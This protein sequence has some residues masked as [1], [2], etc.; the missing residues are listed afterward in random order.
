MRAAAN[1]TNGRPSRVVGVG[2]RRRR[3][4]PACMRARLAGVRAMSPASVRG[5]HL[6]RPRTPAAAM[7]AA[8]ILGTPHRNWCC[9]RCRFY[10]TFMSRSLPRTD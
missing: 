7:F 3:R 8:A 4:V 6:L 5:R 10:E 2:R 9:E 1:G